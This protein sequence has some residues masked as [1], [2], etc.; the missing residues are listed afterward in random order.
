MDDQHAEQ[1]MQ[2]ARRLRSETARRCGGAVHVSFR[3]F[4]PCHTEVG[5]ASVTVTTDGV[6]LSELE[7]SQCR[8]GVA[9]SRAMATSLEQLDT[10]SRWRPPAEGQAPELVANQVWLN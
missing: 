7:H 9:W 2:T 5:Y 10:A 6:R 3:G 1:I 8:S 4:D